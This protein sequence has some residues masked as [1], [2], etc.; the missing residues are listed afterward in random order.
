MFYKRLFT[1][2][3]SST[4]IIKSHEFNLIS[5]KELL[6]THPEIEYIK[7]H[8][9]EPFEYNPF[10]LS[11][12]PEL[13]PHKGLFAKTFIIKIP[14]GQVCSVNGWITLNDHIIKEFI[15]TYSSL[16]NQLQNLKKTSFEKLKKIPGK[17]AVLTMS[18]DICYSHWIY[19]ILGRLALLEL[20]GIEYDW[21]YVAYDKKYMKETLA[22]WGIDPAKII[23][24]FDQT[25]YIQADELIV[26][27]HIGIRAPES[28]Q[29]PLTWVPMEAYSKLWGT[30]PKTT[31]IPYN[32]INKEV[33]IIPAHVE[34]K[35]YF[36]YRNPLCGSYYAPWAIEYIAKKLSTPIQ[37]KDKHFSKKFFISRKDAI[38]RKTVNE[39]ELFALFQPY[40]F[41]R[42]EL[43]K[44]PLAD[45]IALFQQAECIVATHGTG[46]MNLIF[47]K[48]NTTVIE[49]YQGRSDCCFYY[50][51]Q[52]MKLNPYCI[53]TIEFNPADI[54]GYADTT[55][56]LEIIQNFIIM[57]KNL[58]N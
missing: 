58:F 27:S 8:N 53:K 7:C 43:G 21:L 45:Q 23:Q 12:F 49:I 57:N 26:P 6:K 25:A 35:D 54:W 51:A 48:P 5:I 32:T 30:D 14:Q 24:P 3:I 16:A 41:E 28:H 17:V 50:L 2:L 36:I 40:G 44:M 37:V 55:I 47:C 34:V 18:C 13:Q 15:P 22:L 1:F 52:V 39:D 42:Y 38:L 33:D 46:L 56:P 29:Y 19:N 20:Y 31:Y 4:L 11:R 9:I 10:S